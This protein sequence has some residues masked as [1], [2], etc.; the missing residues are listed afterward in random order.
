MRPF[1]PAQAG[2]GT[3]LSPT[4]RPGMVD[5]QDT[6]SGPMFQ[7]TCFR[8]LGRGRCRRHPVYGRVKPIWMQFGRAFGAVVQDGFV[9]L[10]QR[11]RRGQVTR[12]RK[13]QS[14]CLT[15]S[16]VGIL[17]QNKHPHFVRPG[18][19]QC[20]EQVL[21]RGVYLYAGG[22]FLVNPIQNLFQQRARFGQIRLQGRQ[23]GGRNRGMQRKSG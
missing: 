17:P 21:F 7:A 19:V 11:G 22:P 2:M 23:P 3:G 15:R 16:V 10:T 9:N 18:S 4:N 14:V 5:Q 20:L 8:T 13:G 1:H 6:L 12:Y